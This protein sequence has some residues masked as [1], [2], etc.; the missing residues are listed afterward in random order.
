MKTQDTFEEDDLI[1]SL[2]EKRPNESTNA[3]IAFVTWATTPVNERLDVDATNRR[4]AAKTGLE[5]GTIQTYRQI[6]EWEERAAQ[7]EA[8]KF[9]QQIKAEQKVLE[10]DAKSRGE[11][12][13]KLKNDVVDILPRLVEEARNMLDNPDIMKKATPNTA[14]RF[15]EA[16]VKCANALAGIPIEGV[17]VK[18]FKNVDYSAATPEELDALDEQYHKEILQLTGNGNGKFEYV[19]NQ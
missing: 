8:W 10:Q 18:L 13:R 5:V 16:T 11:K 19:D 9:E 2:I 4:I 3:Y 17:E 14:A 6:Y 7:V 15:M 12:L 1:R